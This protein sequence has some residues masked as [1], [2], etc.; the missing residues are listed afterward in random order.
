MDYDPNMARGYQD[1]A[2]EGSTGEGD[3][4]GAGMGDGDSVVIGEPIVEGSDSS[5][6]DSGGEDSGGGGDIP[7]A[8]PEFNLEGAG[9]EGQVLIEKAAAEKTP[10]TVTAKTAESQSKNRAGILICEINFSNHNPEGAS[11]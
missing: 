9:E 8:A 7:P 3:A 5:G 2:W 6:G 10:E 11:V 4:E 1:S